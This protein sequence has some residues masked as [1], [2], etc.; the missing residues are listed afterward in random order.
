[1]FTLTLV[2]LLLWVLPSWCYLLNLPD[3][4][5]AWG[6]CFSLLVGWIAC[7]CACLWSHPQGA[8]SFCVLNVLR[9]AQYTLLL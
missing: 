5:V 1:M 9:Y 8:R 7:V 3:V 6:P 2:W 4:N